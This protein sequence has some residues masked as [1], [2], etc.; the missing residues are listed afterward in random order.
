MTTIVMSTI[1]FSDADVEHRG[2]EGFANHGD[3]TGVRTLGPTKSKTT[4]M[5]VQVRETSVS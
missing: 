5:Y 2:P 1:R 3:V 4:R